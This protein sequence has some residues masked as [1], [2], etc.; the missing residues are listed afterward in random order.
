MVTT[1]HMRQQECKVICTYCNVL[2]AMSWQ[3]KCPF[4]GERVSPHLFEPEFQC[5]LMQQPMSELRTT[6]PHL[7]HPN[8]C[9]LTRVQTG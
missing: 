1:L 6:A 3:Q 2:R 7:H 9:T 5:A 4:L 8:P